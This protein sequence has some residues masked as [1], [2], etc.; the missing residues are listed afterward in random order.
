MSGLHSCRKGDNNNP[1]LMMD[2]YC[3]SSLQSNIMSCYG[4]SRGE[5][6]YSQIITRGIILIE[7]F[8]LQ[9]ETN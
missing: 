6:N 2:D 1:V 3:K 5:R 9:M 4:G 8:E 7:G